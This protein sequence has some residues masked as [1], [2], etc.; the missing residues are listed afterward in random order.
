MASSKFSAEHVDQIKCTHSTQRNLLLNL[1][2]INQIQSVITLIRQIWKLTEFCFIK[3]NYNRVQRIGV[4]NSSK[5]RTKY[6]NHPTSKETHF[7]IRECAGS[8]YMLL[9]IWSFS[10]GEFCFYTEFFSKSH[11]I[12]P[13]SDC[14]NNFPIDLVRNGIL[15]GPKL[16]KK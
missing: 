2:K 15:F 11:W 12:K 6:A 10:R 13:K 14:I 7:L 9:L 4:K 1:V 8:S 3:K 5:R 16:I